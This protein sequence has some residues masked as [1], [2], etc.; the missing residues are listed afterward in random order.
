MALLEAP[1]NVLL[2][3]RLA[4]STPS[5]QCPARFR[6]LPASPSASPPTVGHC[7]TA[8]VLQVIKMLV[9]VVVV[10]VIC[11]APLLVDNVLTAYEVLP[12]SYERVGDKVWLKYMS[13]FFH[14]LSYFNRW[15]RLSIPCPLPPFLQFLIP[16]SLPFAAVSTPSC[17]A[18]CRGASARASVRRC[19]AAAAPGGGRT[20]SPPPTRGPPR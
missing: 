18:S 14:L 13:I 17:T 19:A 4:C 5:P 6:L 16:R 15:V 11:W 1:C 2:S 10:F 7:N 8:S 20:A 12:H 3:A 9:A